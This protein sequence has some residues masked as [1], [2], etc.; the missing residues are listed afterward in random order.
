MNAKTIEK[1]YKAAKE[2]YSKETGINTDKALQI[3][4]AVPL[5]IHCW[6]GDDVGGF[7]RPDSVLDGGGL[8]VTG[9]YPGKARN[10]DELRAD[11]EKAFSLIPGQH[12]A[13]VH[14]IYGE[15]GGKLVDRDEIEPKHFRGWI[16]WAKSAKIGLD[17][18]ASC[19][20]HANAADGYTIS[21]LD[22]GIRKF[23]IEHIL[24]CREISAFMGKE[25]GSACIHNLWIP[26]GCKDE[27]V[28]RWAYRS[29]LKQSLD[30]I[31]TVKHDPKK[32]RDSIEGKLFGIGSEAFVVG[33]NDFYLGYAVQNGVMPCM[34]MGHYH[35]TES[36]AD[37]VSAV[38][39]FCQEILIHASRGVRW[40]SDHVA[41]LSD[42]MRNLLEEIVRIPALDRAHVALDYFD[43]SMNRVGA[44]AIGARS[45]R[46]ALLLA[47][48]EPT[49]R[50]RRFEKD[51]N[52]FA[53]LAL[54]EESKAMPFGAVWEYCCL[55]SN[56]PADGTQLI[57]E[58]L[59]YEAKV[60][61]K[62]K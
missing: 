32:M 49:E 57:K 28:Q 16:D 39:Q 40:D 60:Q 29:R 59:D 51:G 42:E 17:F 36:V 52:S 25:L 44:W 11:M 38:L 33:S 46:K 12:R 54:L 4:Q 41:I 43:G 31:F 53:K 30:E 1:N 9:N 26:D 13:N 24:R 58:V 3:M 37:K 48:L 34:D 35:P 62:R 10:P 21:S 56:V 2:R 55:K 61:S 45:V 5:S 20:S 47:L 8:Q 22:T 6:Q 18:N 50:I 15:F 7:E 19:F 27:S 14:A 23:W